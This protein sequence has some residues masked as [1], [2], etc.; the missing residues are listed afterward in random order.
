MSF[1]YRISTL[2]RQVPVSWT[3]IAVIKPMCSLLLSTVKMILSGTAP[4]HQSISLLD[5]VR[6]SFR[7]IEVDNFILLFYRHT[8][9]NVRVL[10]LIYKLL[11]HKGQLSF[12]LFVFSFFLSGGYSGNLIL[13]YTEEIVK[14]VVR[15][16]WS[17][18]IIVV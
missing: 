1:V 12:Q 2:F 8:W 6:I 7:I 3:F 18:V 16:Y 11:F 5:C 17:I 15:C 13:I 4:G 10:L 9:L 14:L